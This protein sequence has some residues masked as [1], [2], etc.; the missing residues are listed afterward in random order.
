MDVI[1]AIMKIFTDVWALNNIPGPTSEIMSTVMATFMRGMLALVQ[2]I[3]N[4]YQALGNL[5]L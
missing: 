3:Q 5:N 2:M 1:D 4:M